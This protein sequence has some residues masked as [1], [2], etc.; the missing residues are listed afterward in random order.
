[1]DCIIIKVGVFSFIISGSLSQFSKFGLLVDLFV[2]IYNKL[3]SFI[4]YA[5]THHKAP[6]GDVPRGKPIRQG[7][8][9]LHNQYTHADGRLIR[10]VPG[11]HSQ[12][13]Y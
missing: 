7:T 9:G 5:P 10:F 2:A 8:S 1:M 6:H 12:D 3:M 4:D 11:F 13:N